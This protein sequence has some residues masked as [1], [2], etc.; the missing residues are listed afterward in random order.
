MENEITK[1]QF[2]AVFSTFE[3]FGFHMDETFFLNII[4]HFT[5]M[6]PPIEIVRFKGKVEDLAM[7]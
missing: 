4:N 1:R 5:K 7:L 3:L 2:S 6:S